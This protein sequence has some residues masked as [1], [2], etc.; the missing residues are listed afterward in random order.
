V[1]HVLGDQVACQQRVVPTV[2]FDL[3][4]LISPLR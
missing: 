1:I 2:A 4:V 3:G